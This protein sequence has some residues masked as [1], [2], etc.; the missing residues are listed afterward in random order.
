[1]LLTQGSSALLQSLLKANL[2][3]EFRLSIFPVVLGRGKRLFGEGTIPTGLKL[4]ESIV[5]TTGVTINTYVP[6]GDVQ[7][8]SFALEA[9]STE[10]AERRERLKR[11]G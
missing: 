9:P 7:T 2:I 4:K 1:V 6:T 5:S 11:E 10:E 8:G 3:D